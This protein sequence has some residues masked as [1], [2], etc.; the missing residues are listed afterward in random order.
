MRPPISPLR[1]LLSILAVVEMPVSSHHFF[2]AE[3]PAATHHQ[4]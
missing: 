2:K 3:N 4:Q 1:L